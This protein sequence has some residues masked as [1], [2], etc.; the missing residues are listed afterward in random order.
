MTPERAIELRPVVERGFTELV[1]RERFDSV[2]V[3][4]GRD[5]R[6]VLP[7]GTVGASG[8]NIVLA[9]GQPGQRLTQL[10]HWLRAAHA[11]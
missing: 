2:L 1:D 8:S 9:S 11:R 5:Y 10:K 3:V 4:A 7:N 6:A